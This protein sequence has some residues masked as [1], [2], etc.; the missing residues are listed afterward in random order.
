M[1]FEVWRMLYFHFI[2]LTFLKVFVMVRKFTLLALAS[3]WIYS[4]NGQSFSN[5]TLNAEVGLNAYT[6]SLSAE[7]KS[8]WLV[9]AGYQTNEFHFLDSEDQD[10]NEDVFQDRLYGAVLL[11]LLRS[12]KVDHYLG[13]GAALYGTTNS[14]GSAAVGISG[15]LNYK[16]FYSISD[17]LAVSGNIYLLNGQTNELSIGLI[18]KIF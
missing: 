2:Y 6:A 4:A 8:K 1:N 12:E 17:K 13:V 14:S 3:V 5:G 10:N 11:P 7:Y 9:N 18:Y 15:S 16:L